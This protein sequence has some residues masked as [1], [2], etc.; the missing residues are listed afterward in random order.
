MGPSK[1][2]RVSRQIM[3]EAKD[4]EWW[5]GEWKKQTVVPNGY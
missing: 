1:N 2:V 4:N 3:E 5:S